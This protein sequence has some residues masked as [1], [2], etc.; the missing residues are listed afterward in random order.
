MACPPIELQLFGAFRMCVEGAEVKGV[1][2]PVQEL[3]V[4]LAR[5]GSRGIDR[6]SAAADLWPDTDPER[7]QFYMR[8][9]L[10]QTRTV[11]GVHRIRLE[12]LDERRIRL[13]LADCH[14]D[15]VE[16]DSLGRQ[17]EPKA[18]ASAVAC[19]GGDLLL[20]HRSEWVRQE[21]EY[22]RERYVSLLCRLSALDQEAGDFEGAL[23]WLTKAQG[24]NP[25]REETY[26]HLM[27][28]HREMGDFVGIARGF[29][30]LR[31][32]L[33]KAL[34]L[35]PSR[36]TTELYRELLADARIVVPERS[37]DGPQASVRVKGPPSPVSPFIGRE[38]ELAELCSKIVQCRLVTL[39]GLGGVGKSRLAI[40]CAQTLRDRFRGVVAFADMSVCSGLGD[41]RDQIAGA[42]GLIDL[43]ES[44]GPQND[45]ALL[46]VDEVEQVVEAC[47]GVLE[48]LLSSRPSL[49]VLVTSRV[50]LQVA[51]EQVVALQPMTIPGAS[52]TTDDDPASVEA[53]R[54]F[55]ACAER[56]APAFRTGPQNMDQVVELCRRLD[57]I[58]LALEL[59]AVR[60][61]TLPIH[62][63][64][65][66]IDDRF[67]LL[68]EVRVDA[69]KRT[70]E[71]VL[72]WSYRMLSPPERELF[73]RLGV[74]PLSWT[75]TAAKA[76]C[77]DPDLEADEVPRVLG[78][79]VEQSLV[80]F[81]PGT[82]EGTYRMLETVRAYARKVL[83]L[84]PERLAAL[85]ARHADHYLEASAQVGSG[86]ADLLQF[87]A[88]QSNYAAAI[89]TMLQR[90][91]PER[92]MLAQRMVN[93]LFP[94]WY[95]AGTASTG[96]RTALNAIDAFGDDQSDELTEALFRAASAAHFLY[97]ID[98][99]NA[100]F[101]RAEAM[102]DAVGFE[103]WAAASLRDRGE[104][105]ANEGRLEE[106]EQLLNSA[107]ERF[108]GE[109]DLAGEASCLGTLGY[110]ARR[111][112]DLA[113]ARDLTEQALAIHTRIE[114]TE[115]RLWC[116][117]SLAAIYLDAKAPAEAVPLFQETLTLQERAGNRHAQ[118][119]NLTMLGISYAQ[120]NDYRAAEASLRRALTI[121]GLD[122]E[123]M[124]RAWPTLELGEV[125]RL[126]GNLKAAEEALMQA[127]ALARSSGSATIEARVLI[128]LGSVA[129]DKG[130][131]AGARTYRSAASDVLGSSEARDFA[132]EIDALDHA[133]SRISER[134]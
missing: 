74:F 46:L 11:L 84:E 5:A 59:A 25:L 75:L 63:M 15:L 93:R 72:D 17:S 1:P 134:M 119:W 48:E 49:H 34:G 2:K 87:Q 29:R 26:R 79:L 100:L 66:D 3:L 24:A 10:T 109:G 115:G 98:L 114:N 97:R 125:L 81:D 20:G 21:R 69:G 12:A 36:E 101:A 127:L 39:T 40:E 86:E 106:A 78:G 85:Q 14:C 7:A 57:G 38:N 18:L 77:Q 94:S 117:G 28:L 23:A 92:R 71:G 16:F 132:Q 123:D 64:V 91:P 9:C 27:R 51:G 54:F 110:V 103:A 33:R 90:F 111:R 70:L 122:E 61:R 22:Y 120:M 116:L 133:I 102:A 82:G 83:A 67:R 129:I 121:P 44:G 6:T 118:V 108:R 104:L 128:R 45:P 73:V 88:D 80:S 89:D 4:H 99:A 112:G 19:Y 105:A 130:D 52:M 32:A 37:E 47:R 76:V 95:R 96:L 50:A 31:L 58:P 124:R 30:D 107:I 55:L 113:R 62:Q 42:L 60:L 53:V 56:S 131:V 8:R 41:V 126:E 65:R 13:E 43:G 35:S 68:A